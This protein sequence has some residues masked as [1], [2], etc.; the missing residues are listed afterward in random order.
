MV[1]SN[2]R[3]R[4]PSFSVVKNLP[5]NAGDAGL[6]PGSERSPEEG[7]GNTIQYSCLGGPMG[8]S[9]AGYNP[10]GS[11]KSQTKKPQE[12]ESVENGEPFRVMSHQASVI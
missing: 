2:K 1:E 10:R 3:R 4:L 7:N 8:R 5:A 6:I 12:K 9:L 11:Q